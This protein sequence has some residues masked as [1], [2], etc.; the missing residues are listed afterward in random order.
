MAT[1]NVYRNGERI[2]DGLTKK[3]F[4]DTELSPNTTYDYQV[5]AENS[6]GE[7]ELSNP[8]T[9]TTNFSTPTA[10]EVSPK[11]NNLEVG[12]TRNLTATV[13]PNT[14]KQTVVW[15]SSDEDI[16]TVDNTGKVTAIGAGTTTI[17][18]TSTEKSDIKNTVTIN[19]TDPS[20]GDG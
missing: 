19:V 16:A 1:Y 14:A 20:E 6:I 18:V 7:S 2:A 13:S 5:S 4:T 11:T 9:V 3:T 12:A 10:V 8:V 15:F 17:T